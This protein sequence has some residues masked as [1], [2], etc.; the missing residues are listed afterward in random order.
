MLLDAD[1]VRRTVLALAPITFLFF[2]GAPEA[3][4]N[5]DLDLTVMPSDFVALADVDPSI[6][7]EIRYFSTHNFVGRRVKGYRTSKCI[8]TRRAAEALKAVQ[9]ELKDYAL[10]LKVYDCYRPQSAVNDF[11]AWAKDAHDTK[12]KAEFYPRVDKAKLFMDG[13]IAGKSGHS[14]GSTMD[15]TLVALPVRPEP[16]FNEEQKLIACYEPASQRFEDNS[17]DMGTGYDCFDPLAHTANPA[18][19]P[20]Y[21]RQRLLLKAIMEKHGFKNLPEEWWHYTLV[22]EPY[23]STYFNFEIK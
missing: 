19:D 9:S 10:T 20:M 6:V 1:S 18:V 12:M 5:S 16:A 11:V 7:Q 21:R 23:P 4:P 13:Y 17:L 3:Y 2:A 22:D 8:L 15:L 14:R